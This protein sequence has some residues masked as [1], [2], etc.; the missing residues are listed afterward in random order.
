MSTEDYD[1]A[2][3]EIKKD[4]QFAKT[5]P[6]IVIKAVNPNLEAEGVEKTKGATYK[7]FVDILDEMA[8]CNIARYAVVDITDADLFVLNNFKSKGA[9][10]AARE[11]PS[12][13]QKVLQ[14][15]VVDN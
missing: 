10:S 14:L 12:D 3:S 2:V 8:I 1:K 5:A 9:Y 13:A 4:K 7:N 6:V 11:I 15:D